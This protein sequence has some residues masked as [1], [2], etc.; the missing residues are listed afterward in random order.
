[1]VLN[2]KNYCNAYAISYTF[3]HHELNC[4]LEEFIK[5]L[6]KF[7]GGNDVMVRRLDET[8]DAKI[9]R[10]FSLGITCMELTWIL[11]MFTSKTSQRSASQSSLERE[12]TETNG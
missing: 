3:L 8:F 1:M 6:M 12:L 9:S 5:A 2:R 11:L 4:L 10:P 7:Y